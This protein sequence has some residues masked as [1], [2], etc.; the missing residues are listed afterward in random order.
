[1]IRVLLTGLNGR[2]GNAFEE[3]ISET[4]G[5]VICVDRV[6][7]RDDAYLDDDWTGYD[8][9]IHAAG[10]VAPKEKVT[11]DQESHYCYSINHDLSVKV[12]YKAKESGI[13]RFIYLSTMMVYGESAPIGRSFTIMEHTIPVPLSLYGKSKFA[14]EGDISKLA[15]D[16]FQVII[17]REPVVY[18][19]HFKGEFYKLQR[20]ARLL[21]VFPMVDS[22]KSY[23]YERNLCELLRLMAMDGRSGVYCP[24]NKEVVTTSEL[25]RRM[26]YAYGKKC[27]LIYGLRPALSILSYVTR[28]V[29]ATF[30]DMKY[31]PELS[32][33]SGMNY[34]VY[35]LEESIARCLK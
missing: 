12:A 31:E 25:F 9:I 4:C 7:L 21:P 17:I 18:G 23:I 34:Q 11:L 29:N 30:N 20:M 5:E 1:M 27:L 10:V 28:Y 26:R 16:D 35:S 14:A 33:I 6:S 32:C 24:Q 19:E 8:A 15:A 2:I 22:T 3:F 13:K